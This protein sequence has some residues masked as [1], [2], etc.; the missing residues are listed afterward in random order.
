[1]NQR[2]SSTNST[3]SSSEWESNILTDNGFR[4]GSCWMYWNDT[5]LKHVYLRKYI[6]EI[7]VNL[8][9]L[10]RFKKKTEEIEELKFQK[11]LRPWKESK[12]CE[13]CRILLL[14]HGRGPEYP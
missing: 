8:T 11:L 5:N 9:T 6:E 2:V 7:L 1:M 13:L 12:S 3:L 4:A 10:K 14:S